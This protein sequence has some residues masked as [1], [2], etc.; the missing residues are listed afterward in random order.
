MNY[1]DKIF[2]LG[3]YNSFLKIELD[4]DKT[5]KRHLLIC[6]KKLGQVD[7]FFYLFSYFFSIQRAYGTFEQNLVKFKYTQVIN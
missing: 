2:V 5:L 3:F 6:S 1:F 4:C 7:S